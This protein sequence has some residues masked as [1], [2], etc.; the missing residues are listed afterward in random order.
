MKVLQLCKKSPTPQK[1]GESIA[2]HQITKAL[3]LNN[4]EVDV[5]AMLTPKH[6]DFDLKQEYEQVNYNYVAINTNLNIGRKISSILN[7]SELPYILER[8]KHQKFGDELIKTLKSKQYDFIVLEGLFLGIYI[9]VIKKYSKAKIILRAHNVESQIWKRLAVETSNP[10]KKMYLNWIMNP[11]LEQFEKLI[12]KKVDAI[13]AISPI[14]DIYF[15]N[16]KVKCSMCFPVCIENTNTSE[17]PTTFNVGFLGGLDW[18]PNKN[19]VEWFLKNV[20]T[21]FVKKHPSAQ[22]NLAGRNFPNEINSWNAK[23]LNLVGEVDNASVFIQNQTIMIAPIF[24]GSG[25]RV[26]IIEAMSNGKCVVS[27]RIG[28]E[29]INLKHQENVIIADNEKEWIEALEFLFHHPNK[30][31]SIGAQAKKIMEEEY[32]LNSY[33]NKLNSFL[34]KL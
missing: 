22:F 13:L 5:M 2:I 18:L 6:P 11:K 1:D 33:A 14:D 3:L 20:W 28:A 25:M 30:I 32:S 29:G 21:I 4:A 9:E 26:K 7:W 17:L 12:L 15:K 16:N 10:I 27:S 31:I 34:N 8:F 23:G 24:S 19:G